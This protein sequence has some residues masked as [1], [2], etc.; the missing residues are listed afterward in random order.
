MSPRPLR[1]LAVLPATAALALVGW[2]GPAAPG[3]SA[4]DTVTI[5]L[6]PAYVEVSFPSEQN[7]G[8]TRVEIPQQQHAFQTV[9]ARWGGAVT[10][11]MPPQEVDT[12]H[13]GASMAMETTEGT[14]TGA[15]STDAAAAPE[16]RLTMTSLGN[17]RYRIQLPADDGRNGPIGRLQIHGLELKPGLDVVPLDP[18]SFVLHLSAQGPAAVAV[19][20]QTVAVSCPPGHTAGCA[21]VSPL[22]AGAR[23][24]VSLPLDSRLRALGLTGLRNSAFA[25]QP[26]DPHSWPSPLPGTSL[27]ATMG[28]SD[29]ATATMTVPAGMKPGPYQFTAVVGNSTGQLVTM[30]ALDVQ[31]VASA[32]GSTT[33]STGAAPSTTG[34]TPPSSSTPQG[35]APAGGGSDT[36]G[37]NLTGLWVALGS[38]LVLAAGSVVGLVGYRRHHPHRHRTA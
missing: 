13:V 29:A 4:T 15:Y 31:V 36:G 30:T 18:V 35:A 38:V 3:A 26:H 10:A 20:Q 7:I 5:P 34:G 37:R 19:D 27:P 12:G 21:T 24:R 28:T 33:P 17:N 32:T 23:I 8:T 14:H 9:E 1:L 16:D 22:P 25:L 2:V 6:A 11:T